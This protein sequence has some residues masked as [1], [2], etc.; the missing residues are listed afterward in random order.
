MDKLLDH[1]YLIFSGVAPAE[2]LGGCSPPEL[3]LYPGRYLNLHA[4]SARHKIR[5]LF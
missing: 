5:D 4:P 2:G 1:C 3:L